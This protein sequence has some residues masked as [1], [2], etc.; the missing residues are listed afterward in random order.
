[1]LATAMDI[2]DEKI[3]LVE[4]KDPEGP[5]GAKGVGEIG[6]NPTAAAIANAIYDAVGFR[7]RKL[8]I[9]AEDV[10]FFLHPEKR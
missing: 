2:P 7:P 9:K 5:Y 3:F 4:T 6:L 10:Y 8:P 1:M